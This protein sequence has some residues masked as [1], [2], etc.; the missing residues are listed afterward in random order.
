MIWQFGE[1][2]YDISIDYDGRTSPKPLR[3]YYLEDYR[4]KYLYDFYSSLI[5]LKQSQDIFHTADFTMNVASAVKSISLSSPEMNMVVYGNFD[6]R[7]NQGVPGFQHLG[8]WYE[9][10]TGDTIVVT[11][12]NADMPL[13]HGEYKL[14]TDVPLPKPQIG[15][16]TPESPA[17]NSSSFE[18]Y[19]NPSDHF[20][21]N[22]NLNQSARVRIEV[23]DISGRKVRVLADSYMLKGN[24]NLSW[25]T[26]ETGSQN[27]NGIYL[28]KLTN[29]QSSLVR[30]IIVQ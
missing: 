29:D 7:T 15:T 16:G 17:M 12:L 28:I 1:I 20:F 3:W 22:F 19:P 24:H 13:E 8:T 9:Y 14:Y 18:V 23:F 30:K 4:R 26:A 6:F 5:K 10:F 21:L 27:L 11:D 2:G 25:N